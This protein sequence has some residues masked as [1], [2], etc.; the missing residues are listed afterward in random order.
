MPFFGFFALKM[1][2]VHKYHQLDL[3]VMPIAIAVACTYVL[4]RVSK[5]RLSSSLTRTKRTPLLK[6]VYSKHSYISSIN[7]QKYP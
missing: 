3:A 1:K 2:L 7:R 4:V 6:L 5:A